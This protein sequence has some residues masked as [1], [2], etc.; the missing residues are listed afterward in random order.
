M[1]KKRQSFMPLL[2]TVLMFVIIVSIFSRI[3]DTTNNIS[4]N[5]LLKFLSSDNVT[6]VTTQGNKV[7]IITKDK[8]RYTT[9]LPEEFQRNFYKDYLENKVENNSINYK[10][11]EQSESNYI[12]QFL[13]S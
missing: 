8:Q 5:E 1:N 2:S 6:D 12:I 9:V 4:V 13:P 7:E 10:G 3:F 11:I